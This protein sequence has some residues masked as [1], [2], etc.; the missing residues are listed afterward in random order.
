MIAVITRYSSDS[1]ISFVVFSFVISICHMQI[2]D[3]RCFNA[4]KSSL[5]YLF[6]R[7]TCTSEANTN[8]FHQLP[9]F[10]R[11]ASIGFTQNRII[12]F[13]QHER[14]IDLIVILHFQLFKKIETLLTIFLLLPPRSLSKKRCRTEPFL[15]TIL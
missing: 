7:T 12:P 9:L 14:G 4:R 6:Y 15:D 13:L 1:K 8:S 3:S 11:Q 5:H 2:E 10:R